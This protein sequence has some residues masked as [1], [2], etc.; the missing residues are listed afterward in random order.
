MLKMM[1]HELMVTHDGPDAIRMAQVFHPTLTLLDIGLPG[2]NGYLLA[3]QLRNIPELEG[4]VIA[5]L[6]GYGE[7]QD[8][9]RSR[10]AGFDR[11]F[12]KPLNFEK[13]N[14]LIDSMSQPIPIHAGL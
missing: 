1:G 7:P 6:T 9:K 3:E 13:L 14:E 8:R 4:M 2:M 11:H 12:V 5:A 10:A